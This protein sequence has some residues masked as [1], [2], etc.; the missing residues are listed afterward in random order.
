M[1]LQLGIHHTVFRR[2]RH[3]GG[4]GLVETGPPPH[5]AAHRGLDVVGQP[6]HPSRPVAA[7]V[8]VDYTDRRAHAGVVGVGEMHAGAN[9]LHAQAISFV[10]QF[11]PALP[12]RKM[13]A[14]VLQQVPVVGAAHEEARRLPAP[15]D[16]PGVAERDREPD[17]AGQIRRNVAQM[18]QYPRRA[19]R[20][21]VRL[22][23][24]CR[25]QEPAERGDQRQIHPGQDAAAMTRVADR[26]IH[27]P[28]CGIGHSGFAQ[29]A[30]VEGE[31][32]PHIHAVAVA[33]ISVDHPV[34]AELHPRDPSFDV[35]HVP[36]AQVSARV[37]QPAGV[38]TVGGQQQ[39]GG[40]QTAGRD[41][42]VGGDHLALGAGQR[43]DHQVIDA[44]AGRLGHDLGAGESGP[45][46]Q[47]GGAP[48]RFSIMPAEPGGQRPALQVGAADGAVGQPGDQ[49]PVRE[50]GDV[51]GVEHR[52]A[53]GRPVAGPLQVRLDVVVSDRPRRLF[54]DKPVLEVDAVELD[55]APTPQR[56]GSSHLPA[57]RQPAARMEI[58]V[59]PRIEFG[60]LLRR[61]VRALRTAFDQHHLHTRGGEFQR[62]HDA[63]RAG[64]DDRHV[65]GDGHAGG[66][67]PRAADHPA[68]PP[69]NSVTRARNRATVSASGAATAAAAS[70]TRGGRVVL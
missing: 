18:R 53:A 28:Y 36:A 65:G 6:L 46:R 55:A 48:Q 15:P 23:D 33:F 51:A 24:R 58:V 68:R 2:R 17:R 57:H 13:L 45:Q 40:L 25:Q 8:F 7:Q 39:P 61:A 37:A 9:P 63:D 14:V 10:R 41:D 19:V 11:D 5:V 44:A 1:H 31:A 32:A 20:L 21:G 43:L 54:G 66:E 29:Q 16:E 59:V 38:I 4:S 3:P 49:V 69:R 64:P 62:G 27:Q 70:A 12:V 35:G 34:G 47:S 26:G 42:V 60:Q 22:A 67:V 30:R 50:F 52:P 56:R